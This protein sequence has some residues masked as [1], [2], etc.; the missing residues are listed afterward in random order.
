MR[1]ADLTHSARTITERKGA[2]VNLPTC[3]LR[4]H[5]TAHWG[6]ALFGG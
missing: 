2:V 3:A 5:S 6:R 1:K 4:E